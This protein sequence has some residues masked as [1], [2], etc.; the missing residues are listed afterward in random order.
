MKASNSHTIIRTM[1]DESAVG[2]LVPDESL[3]IKTKQQNK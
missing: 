3:Q 1:V 2:I